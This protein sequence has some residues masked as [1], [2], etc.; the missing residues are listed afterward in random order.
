MLRKRLKGDEEI[1]SEEGEEL[2]GKKTGGKKAKG[3]K[4]ISSFMV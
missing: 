1:E 2:K 4:N 3:I